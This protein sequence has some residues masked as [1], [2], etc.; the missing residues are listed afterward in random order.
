MSATTLHPAP[1]ELQ[2]PRPVPSSAA[3]ARWASLAIASM[4][5]CVLFVGLFGGDII[6]EN[7]AGGAGTGTKIPAA[8]ALAVLAL[9]ATIAIARRAF[10][11][12]TEVAQ[13]REELDAERRAREVLAAQV[14]ELQAR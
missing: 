14:A 12:G 3:T 1:A 8:V 13:L 5:L 9:P 10:G 2:Q 11:P 7:G 6:T 4:W